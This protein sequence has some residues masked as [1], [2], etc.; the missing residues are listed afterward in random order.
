MTRTVRDA[1]L[2]L[3][4][5]A[6]PDGRDPSSLP[7]AGISY[8]KAAEGNVKGLRCA[9]SADLGY[10]AVE[11]EVLEICRRAIAVF[12]RLG[13]KVEEV[14]SFLESPEEPFNAMAATETA[15]TWGHLLPKWEEKLDP[16][17]IFF[18]K[19]GIG[20]S[21]ISYVKAMQT[22]KKVWNQV[23]Q[24]FRHYDLLLTPTVA[25]P[26]FAAGEPG[27]T[28]IAGR[29]VTPGIGWIPFTYPF[30]MTGHPAASVPAGFTSEGLPVGLQ[31]VGRRWADDCVLRASRAFEEAQPWAHLRPQI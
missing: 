3:D 5:I 20:G 6:G 16:G 10:A 26:P 28:E 12:E 25:V 9:W 11:S 19:L 22:R 24:L 15:T 21:A 2:M 13:T 1:A 14:K 31:L 27:P 23:E 17:F 18:V 7:A 30:N 29:S 4:V 8:S